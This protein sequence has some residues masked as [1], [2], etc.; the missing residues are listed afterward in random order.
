MNNGIQLKLLYNKLTFNVNSF[1]KTQEEREEINELFQR[2]QEILDI[3][4]YN[5]DPIFDDYRAK[6]LA[7]QKRYQDMDADFLKNKLFEISEDSDEEHVS[8]NM[9][10]LMEERNYIDNSYYAAN[11]FLQDVINTRRNV[12]DGNAALTRTADKTKET[13]LIFQSITSVMRLI[14]RHSMKNRIVLGTVITL[15][16]IFIIW[17]SL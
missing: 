8:V 3:E 16:I 10:T 13:N 9:K 11:D 14:K 12:M 15:C 17:W 4:K 5:S 2:F 7:I 6:Y 1:S